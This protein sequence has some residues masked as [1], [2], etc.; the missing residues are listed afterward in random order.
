MER[1]NAAFLAIVIGFDFYTVNESEWKILC[2]ITMLEN[3]T[4]FILATATGDILFEN[5]S[6]A[7]CS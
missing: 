4:V 6:D 5:M 3:F 2:T 1:G 7:F